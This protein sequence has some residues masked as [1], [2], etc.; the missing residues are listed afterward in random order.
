MVL[1]P[2]I[3]KMLWDGKRKEEEEGR[4]REGSLGRSR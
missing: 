4:D 2:Y 1:S 3:L